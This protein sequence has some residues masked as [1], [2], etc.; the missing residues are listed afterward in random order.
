MYGY[1]PPVEDVVNEFYG[2]L[3][4]NSAG[5]IGDVQLVTN[6][7]NTSTNL[8]KAI[9]EALKA[10]DAEIAKDKANDNTAKMVGI[11]VVTLALASVV[12]VIVIKNKRRG[13]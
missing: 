10:A 12:T 11:A 6:A 13:V 5:T 3:P 4:G 1:E 7:T 2:R 8:V 9:K